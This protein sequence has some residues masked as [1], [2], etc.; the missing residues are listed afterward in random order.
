MEK[1]G[2]AAA[3]VAV[4]PSE[5]RE[6]HGTSR[7]QARRSAGDEIAEDF[8]SRLP[9]AVLGTII[10][11]LPTKEGGRT[12]ALSRRW[13]PLW[14]CAPLNLEVCTGAPD[15][16]A[17][18]SSIPPS[19]VSEIISRHPGPTRRFSFPGLR[20]GEFDAELESWFR[21]RALVN[22][23]ELEISYASQTIRPL[24]LFVL[25][26]AS[27]LLAL[28]ISNCD[29][30]Q[31][32]VPAMN[33]PVL[34][35][36]SLENVSIAGEVFH[37]LLSCCSAL[38]SLV[39]CEVRSDRSSPSTWLTRRLLPVS[40]LSS[41]STI[42]AAKITNCDFSRES[43]PSMVFPLLKQLSLIN[44]SIPGDVLQG[45]LLGCHALESLFMSKVR[46]ASRL[47]DS[48]PTLKI[49][50][51][52]LRSICLTRRSYGITELVIEDAPR[53]E[54]LL[55]PYSD[56]D[57]CVTI[58][59][60][61]AP[62]LEILGPIPFR[63]PKQEISCD[64]PDFSKFRIFQGMTPVSLANSMC[65]VKVLALRSSGTELHAVLNV[66][67]WFPCVEKLTVIFYEHNE[68]DKINEPQYDPL[69]PIECVETHLKKVVFK[70]YV[71]Y[72]NQLDFARFFVLNAKVLQKMEFEGCY[73]DINNMASFL[74]EKLQV[75]N[76]ASRDAEFEFKN[77]SVR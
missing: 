24:P 3:A 75:E 15:Y 19:A 35:Q 41:A 31:E 5:K 7:E 62:K 61:R 51:P 20:A 2:A 40:V 44:V 37:G 69:H 57:D 55:V 45:L 30:C 52:T 23:Q 42:L 46:T 25:R 16:P 72:E 65:T 18:A 50:S 34:K 29:F 63:T 32:I 13:R 54:R 17:P 48:S 10:S 53:L 68:M 8:I 11:L 73:D 77:N 66:L 4:P 47:H 14:L 67:R 9:D 1:K 76:R 36:L 60:I 49:S 12:Q 58:R 26:S 59:V 33:F 22:L 70:S 74:N 71:G 28:K 64:S 39:M 6:S 43:V 21:S 38:E 27:T 56:R